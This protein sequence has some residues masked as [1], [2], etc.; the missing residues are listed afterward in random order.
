MQTQKA[1]K[2]TQSLYP[3]IT[4]EFKGALVVKRFPVTYFCNQAAARN[5]E[6]KIEERVKE[7]EKAETQRKHFRKTNQDNLIPTHSQSHW[8]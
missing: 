5:S 8:S 1:R 2:V 6:H 3:R 4:G 7:R